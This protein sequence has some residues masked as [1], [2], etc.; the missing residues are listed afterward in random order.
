M[1]VVQQWLS[2]FTAKGSG[3]QLD[4]QKQLK[5]VSKND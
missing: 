5:K 2:S 4:Y 3:L 1:G